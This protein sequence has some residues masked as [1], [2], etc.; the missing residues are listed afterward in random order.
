MP[1]LDLRDAA[2]GLH[3]LASFKLLAVMC[4]PRDPV[5]RQRMLAHLRRETGCGT[6]RVAALDRET[7][8]CLV[9]RDGR[10]GQLAGALLLTMLQLHGNGQPATLEA[11][12][13]IV[14]AQLPR[15]AQLQAPEW[16]RDLNTGHTPHSRRKARESFTHWRPV[17]HFWAA[18]VHAHEHRRADIS[19]ELNATLPRFIAYAEA[20]ADLASRTRWLSRNGPLVPPSGQRWTA[21]IP[22]HLRETRSVKTMPLH[23]EQQYLLDT[24]LAGKASN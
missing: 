17:V 21:A 18:Y 13:A 14:A 1:T 16:H 10:R 2:C 22:A 11:A 7:F 12:I 20:F 5:A 15:W 6:P 9:E 3:P 23:P 19:L 24:H 4:H 8:L